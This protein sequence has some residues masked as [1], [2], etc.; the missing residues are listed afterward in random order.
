MALLQTD[1]CISNRID[2]HA[3][4]M[5]LASNLTFVSITGPTLDKRSAKAMRAHV[6]KANFARR[7]RRLVQDH[8]AQKEC[9]ACAKRLKRDEHG[10]DK[11]DNL[12]VDV[13]LP[14]LG[15][16]GLDQQLNRTDAFY[17]HHC[18]Y[19]TARQFVILNSYSKLTYTPVIVTQ[20]MERLHLVPGIPE[21]EAASALA[22]SDWARFLP[23]PT[24]LDVSLYFARHVDVARKKHRAVQ[25]VVDTYK[26]KAIQS[27]RERLNYGS[28]D[29]SDSLVAATLILTITNVGLYK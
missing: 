13:Q 19:N 23:D 27:V 1:R 16:P 8:V 15:H 12:A 25:I 20:A 21:S 28:E 2:T 18:A 24:M 3:S 9:T 10:I 17:I 5:G 29:L 6:T 14:I 26:G 7:R 11:D 4:K 22:Q